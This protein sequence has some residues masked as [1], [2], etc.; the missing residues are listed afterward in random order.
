MKQK[1]QQKSQLMECVQLCWEC[2][3]ECQKTLYDYCLEEG[4][5]HADP[6]HV[7]LM[8]DCIEIC[9]VAAD[10]MVRNSPLYPSVCNAC[11][12]ICEACAESC[13]ELDDKEMEE[14]AEIC[15]QCAESCRDMG[16]QRKAA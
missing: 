14:L 6:D 5:E 1:K 2:R 12:D 9:Q 15:S 7:K 16:Q 4:G 8:A 10:F 13:E 3:N 11:A